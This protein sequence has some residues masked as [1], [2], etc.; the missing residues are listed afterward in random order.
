[1]ATSFDASARELTREAALLAGLP[2]DTIL[3]EEPQAALY[4]W[5]ADMGD[6]WRRQSSQQ[7]T[8]ACAPRTR[9]FRTARLLGRSCAPFVLARQIEA[10]K[11][12]DD[13]IAGD[14]DV[15]GDFPAGEPGLKA[16]FQQFDAF[17]SP[18]GFGGKHDD[19]P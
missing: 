4:A 9:H 15:G 12:A 6:K 5:L 10:G 17:R 3:L 1:M 13:R 8:L 16:A 19:G 11:L 18:G 2:S 7:L 14:A